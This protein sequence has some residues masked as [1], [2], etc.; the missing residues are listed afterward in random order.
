MKGIRGGTPLIPFF[1]SLFSCQKNRT[2][3]I[4]DKRLSAISFIGYSAKSDSLSLQIKPTIKQ[5]KDSYDETYSH[6]VFLV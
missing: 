5:V 6:V 1:L 2:D 4:L 3:L